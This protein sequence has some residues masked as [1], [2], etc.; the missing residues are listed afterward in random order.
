MFTKRKGKN[1]KIFFRLKNSVTF[2]SWSRADS[3]LIKVSE[4]KV[5]SG[6]TLGPDLAVLKTWIQ[7]LEL[8]INI[9][10]LHYL[11]QI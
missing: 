3:P 2:R 7:L 6:P 5:G 11:S 4:I 9:I 1:F 10:S 8:F